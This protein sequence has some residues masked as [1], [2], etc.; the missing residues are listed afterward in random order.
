MTG[1]RTFY[2]YPASSNACV[3]VG[4]ATFG[5]SGVNL[6]AHVSYPVSETVSETLTGDGDGECRSGTSPNPTSRPAASSS[7][8]RMYYTVF[9]RLDVMTPSAFLS[10]QSETTVISEL[11]Q[12]R[13]AGA[14]CCSKTVLKS[15]SANL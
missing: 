12:P 7:L 4:R 10:T 9:R 3:D 2:L 5:F 11:Q 15:E 6:R 8:R 13:F 14:E 1:K